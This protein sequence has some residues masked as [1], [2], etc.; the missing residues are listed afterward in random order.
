MADIERG[1]GQV[2]GE[3]RWQILNASDLK[4]RSL[5]DGGA[6]VSK[7]EGLA[8]SK[9]NHAL[10]RRKLRV[11]SQAE[12]GSGV[13]P[14]NGM[15]HHGL[16]C[17]RPAYSI[18]SPT[19]SASRPPHLSC[20]HTTRLLPFLTS[21]RPCLPIAR[22]ACAAWQPTLIMS[23]VIRSVKNVTKGYSSVQVKVR[24]GMSTALARL[25]CSR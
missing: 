23:S 17:V 8:R 20:H 3:Q 12:A 9:V 25:R 21:Q 2:G 19:A 10:A 18:L 6:W 16:N 15:E 14:S 4:M 11:V 13:A 22:Y 7:V 1:A 24:N 5:A